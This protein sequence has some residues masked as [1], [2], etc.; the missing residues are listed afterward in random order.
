[1]QIDLCNSGFEAIKALEAVRYDLVFMDHKMPEMDGVETVLK[2]RAMGGYESFFDNVPIIALTA[3]AVSGMKE[4]FLE[5]GF[6]D[7]I[8][9]PIDTL[10]LNEILKKWLPKEKQQS[11]AAKHDA[12]VI[13]QDAGISIEIAGLDVKQGALRS[14]GTMEMYF[15]TLEVFYK[16][17]HKK[18]KEIKSSLENGALSQYTIYVHALKSACANIGAQG[19][20]DAAKRLEIA[21]KNSDWKYIEKHNAK[22]LLALES[23]LSHIDDAV[24]RKTAAAPKDVTGS[25]DWE[26]FHSELLKLKSALESFDARTMKQAIDRLQVLAQ[27]EGISAEVSSI[28]ENILLAEFDEAIALIEVLLEKVKY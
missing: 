27:P 26:E 9:K 20:S 15:K 14:G 11:R 18:I 16:D 17:G 3:N 19:L 6:N 13:E 4:M 25:L 22:F 5:N 24:K 8:S 7:F 10:E 12:A 23:T 1:M 28:A 21:G 2:I